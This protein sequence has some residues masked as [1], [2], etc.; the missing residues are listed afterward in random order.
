MA[1]PVGRGAAQPL[2]W[3][4]VSWW[5]RKEDCVMCGDQ[6]GDLI[7]HPTPRGNEL[8]DHVHRACLQRWWAALPQNDRRNHTCS[9]CTLRTEDPPR[10]L[11]ERA[12]EWL[13]ATKRTLGNQGTYFVNWLNRIQPGE[14]RV[15]KFAIL[16]VCWYGFFMG[17]VVALTIPVLYVQQGASIFVGGSLVAKTLFGYGMIGAAAAGAIVGIGSELEEHLAFPS[18][19][20]R[21]SRVGANLLTG[22]CLYKV[23]VVAWSLI[24]GPPY[25]GML[26]GFCVGGAFTYGV[27]WGH[28]VA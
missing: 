1:A 28:T 12:I 23:L 6:G 9:V 25:G 10:T 27:K 11:T 2:Q 24:V 17:S 3:R 13:S 15:F 14:A 8:I 18:L 5:G 4:F 7:A 22:Y 20:G 16:G 19:M 26:V 21:V